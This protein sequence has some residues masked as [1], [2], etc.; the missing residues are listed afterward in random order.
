MRATFQLSVPESSDHGIK[1][2][3]YN[4]RVFNVYNHLGKQAKWKSS[5]DMIDWI[6]SEDFDIMCFQEFYYEPNSKTFNTIYKLKSKRKYY[7]YFHK[8]VTNQINGQFGM[9]IFSKY[10]IVNSGVVKFDKTNNQILYVDIL[11][12]G[13]TI[14]VYNCH[15]VSNSL[16]EGDVPDARI[17]NANKSKVRSMAGILK[18]G[19][20]R[21]GKQVDIL[22]DHIRSNSKKVILC[23]DLNDLP[24]SYTYRKLSAGLDNCFEKK[25]NG[26]GFSFNG[27]IPFLR[28]DNIFVND[29]FN[30]RKFTTYTNVKYSDHFPIS[31]VIEPHQ[32]M[33]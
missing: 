24:Y 2:L 30:T 28:I 21:R 31:A 17:S 20:K 29:S 9:A 26:F 15:L 19:F 32:E 16:Q 10:K 7:H 22:S 12:K 3:S 18:R 8:M 5:K 23:G 6:V 33:K 27:K 13:D 14:R 4:V 25:G 11:A 1:V